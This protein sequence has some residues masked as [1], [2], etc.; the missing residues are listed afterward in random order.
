[1]P[2]VYVIGTG[3]TIAAEEKTVNNRKVWQAGTFP[4][5]FIISLPELE[6]I[7]KIETKDLFHL[8]SPD[9]TPV[10]WIKMAET[11]Y[12][13]INSVD[14]V[15]ITHGTDTMHYTGAALSFMLQN[16]NK[17]VVI[18]GSQIAPSVLG[19]DA[20]RNLVDSVKVAAEADIAEVCITFNGKILRANRTKKCY[21]NGFDAFECID[22]PIGYIEP[23]IR[24]KEQ[25]I[26]KDSK[27][28]P[29]LDTK[30]N[31]KIFLLKLYPGIDYSIITKI[32]SRGYKGLVIE[33]YGAGNVPKKDNLFIPR[34]KD[35][36]EEGIPVIITTQCIVGSSW[37][38]Q[39]EITHD[40]FKLGAIDCQDMLSETALVKLMWVLGHTKDPEKIHKMM[41]T[42]YAGEI[43]TENQGQNLNIK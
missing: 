28:K 1:M 41:R 36:I 13:K 8:R 4:A 16:L 42:N 12:S 20:R 17:P 30:I 40:A 19:S 31:D 25:Y 2:K 21:A 24:L 29:I 32:M 26:K 27:K 39:Y 9:M 35:L 3:G 11:V 22:G 37:L 15:V 38:A 43:S 5:D 34:I 18:T 23:N 7:A 14:G 33:A 10:N 6:E